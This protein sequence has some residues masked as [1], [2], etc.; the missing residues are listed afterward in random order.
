MNSCCMHTCVCVV[1][2]VCVCFISPPIN[3]LFTIVLTITLIIHLK[4]LGTIHL[5]C[6]GLE[7]LKKN[8]LFTEILVTNNFARGVHDCS[9]MFSLRS[10][11]IIQTP[12]LVGPITPLLIFPMML[13]VVM[14]GIKIRS[15]SLF[16]YLS[17][18]GNF[19]YP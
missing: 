19:S 4:L 10:L 5:I 1:V 9:K 8:K 7:C 15:C 2:Y 16:C 13:I 12:K 18:A 3:T 14:F 11:I 6:E 17:L